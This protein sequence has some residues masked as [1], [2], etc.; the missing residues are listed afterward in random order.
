[1]DGRLRFVIEGDPAGYGLQ[2]VAAYFQFRRRRVVQVASERFVF[3]P[4]DE[5]RLFFSYRHTPALVSR[6]LAANGLSVL[7]HW[8]PRSAEE[9]VFLAGVGTTQPLP[10]G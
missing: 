4:R 10:C 1:M 5:V 6:L 2:R 8:M 9:G 3:G 7:R